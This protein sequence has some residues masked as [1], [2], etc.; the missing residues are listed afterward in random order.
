MNE[1]CPRRDPAS[2]AR[3][4]LRRCNRAALATSRLGAPYASLVLVA[5]DLDGSPL[6][7]LSDLAQH[8]RNL[9]FDPRL[10]LLFDATEGHPDPLAGPRLTVLGQVEAVADRRRLARFA[11]R[12]PSAAAYAG[13]ADFRLYRVAVER[14]HLVAGF[15]R[16][17][18]IEAAALL[19]ASDTSALAAAEPALL[20]RLN[21]DHPEAIARCAHQLLGRSGDGW[22]LTGIDPDGI[23]LRR[24]DETGRL[25]FPGA[26]FTLGEVDAAFARLVQ[27]AR[28]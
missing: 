26:V 16:I 14:G 1:T 18:W 24:A 9:A 21:Q 6:L 5:A 11:A 10:S 19:S 8:S 3:G 17:E 13:F 27:A 15:G 4:L 12:H 7:L 28:R 22:R 25:E 2:F 20:A 23:D